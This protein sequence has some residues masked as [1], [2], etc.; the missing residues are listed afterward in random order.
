[1]K[2]ESI[3]PICGTLLVLAG[4][5]GIYFKIEYSGWVIFAGAMYLYVD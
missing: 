5:V 2:K 3:K 1:M 4:M